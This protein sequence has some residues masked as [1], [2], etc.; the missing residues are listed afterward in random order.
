MHTLAVFMPAKY[1]LNAV[2]MMHLSS[3]LEILHPKGGH[4]V[5]VFLAFLGFGIVGLVL[6]ILV[7]VCA[8]CMY[9]V[10]YQDDKKRLEIV[11]VKNNSK[12]NNE[13]E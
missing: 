12:S 11:P 10:K 6:I 2:K 5:D 7:I 8:I 3:Y 13:N 1:S 4:Q 9:K